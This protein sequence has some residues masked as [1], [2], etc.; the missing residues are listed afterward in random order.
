MLC[1][2]CSYKGGIQHLGVSWFYS[3]PLTLEVFL[4]ELVAAGECNYETFAVKK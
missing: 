3:P 1:Q 2:T 4:E